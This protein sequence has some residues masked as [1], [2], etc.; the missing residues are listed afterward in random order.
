[1]N[2]IYASP[3]CKLEELKDIF[4]ELTARN[5]NMRCRECYIE[6][7]FNKNIKD[8]I[9]T[10]A[11]K[12][13]L[14]QLKSQ[15]LRCIYLTGAEPMTHPDFNSILRLCIQKSDV[16]ICTNA[17]FINEK[18]ARFLK[19]VELASTNNI[20]FKL[21]F[22]HWDEIKNDSV[23][24]RGAYRQNIFALKCLDKYE[25]LNIIN[26]SNYYK[27]S[28]NKLINEFQSK[29][30]DIGIQNAVIQISEWKSSCQNS[31]LNDTNWELNGATDCMTSRTL[32]STGIFACPF[33]ANDYRGRMGSDFNNYSKTIRL[34]TEF[35]ATCL[36]NKDKIF[37]VE[38]E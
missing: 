30:S 8:F 35:C 36:R 37:T 18:K 25:F 4:I 15:E 33:L 13:G 31:P 6:F 3:V 12:T 19:N 9:K 28:H 29:L 10:D 21:S 38:L 32:T 5:C 11:V 14:E 22:T 26:I 7:P 20:S 34:E 27:E 16:C 2:T 17:S 23:R 24:S 1:M